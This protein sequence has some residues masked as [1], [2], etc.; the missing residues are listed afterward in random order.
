MVDLTNL[1]AQGAQFA[2]DWMRDNVAPTESRFAR[3]IAREV[4]EGW[5]FDADAEHWL[6]W[7][8]MHWARYQ[9][10]RFLQLVGEYVVAVADMLLIGGQISPTERKSLHTAR[11]I[12]AI[13]KICR[14]LPTMLARDPMFDTHP[15]LFNTPDGTIDLRTGLVTP[16]NSADRITILAPVSPAAR[17]SPMPMFQTFLEL[18][19]QGNKEVERM[20]QEWIGSSMTGRAPDQRI[21]FLFGQGGNGKSVFLQV[22]ARLM[23]AYHQ[24]ADP[25][26]LIAKRGGGADHPAGIAK[27]VKARMVTAVEVPHNA[28]WNTGLIKQLTGGDIVATRFMHQNF[29]DA[30]PCCSITVAGNEKPALNNVDEAIRRRFLLVDFGATIQNPIRNYDTKLIEAEGPAI[31]RWMVEGARA[32]LGADD[33]YVAPV[34]AQSSLAYFTE[35]DLVRQFVEERCTIATAEELLADPAA[36]GTSTSVLFEAFRGFAG[37][38]GRQPGSRNP[39]STKLVAITGLTIKRT[40]SGAVVVGLRLAGGHFG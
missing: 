2:V 8:G 25:T 9:T 1:R 27:V 7:S 26:L 10:P 28:A 19:T 40:K 6:E 36:W 3:A 22:M 29:F 4:E 24:A 18:I 14:T 23:G 39:F 20:L 15:F 11:T 30:L 34:V 32:R 37:T 38:M 5:L 16:G 31:M 35:E 21:M 33:L 12:S 13:E 17:G